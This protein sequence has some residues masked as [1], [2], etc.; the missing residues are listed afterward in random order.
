MSTLLFLLRYLKTNFFFYL[1]VISSFIVIIQHGTLE[2]LR[3]Q[4]TIKDGQ[5]SAIENEALDY[6]VRINKL[7]EKV[8]EDQQISRLN[9]QRILSSNVSDNCKDSMAWAVNQSG[10]LKYN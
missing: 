6:T 8:K 10:Y 9:S 4:I 7:Q 1:F 2:K 3:H 5:L